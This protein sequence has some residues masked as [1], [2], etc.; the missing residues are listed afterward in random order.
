MPEEKNEEQRDDD[1]HG[2][3]FDTGQ[4]PQED[5][6]CPVGTTEK[7]SFKTDNQEEQKGRHGDISGSK[8]QMCKKPWNYEEQK[9]IKYPGRKAVP[10]PPFQ[11]DHEAD[12]EDEDIQDTILKI[13]IFLPKGDLLGY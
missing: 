9:D 12:T 3:D 6:R 13:G 4:Q 8:M 5:S 1:D 10:P 7:G 2:G 11:E